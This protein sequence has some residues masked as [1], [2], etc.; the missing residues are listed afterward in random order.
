ML[1][2]QCSYV[3]PSE[4]L[5]NLVFFF[6]EKFVSATENIVNMTCLNVLSVYYVQTSHVF[7]PH[8]VISSAF[9][10]SP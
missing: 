10:T 6:F 4:N 2:Q 8:G 5:R 7:C 3:L 9:P 1:L